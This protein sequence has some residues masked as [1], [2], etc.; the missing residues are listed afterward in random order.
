MNKNYTRQ[1]VL[2]MKVKE[3]RNQGTKRNT[4][5][6]KCAKLSITTRKKHNIQT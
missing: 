4:A 3:R 1:T 6:A 5:Q 2:Y